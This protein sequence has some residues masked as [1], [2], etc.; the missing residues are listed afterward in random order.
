MKK[1]IPTYSN[2]NIYNVGD[3]LIGYPLEN[4]NRQNNN[5]NIKEAIQYVSNTLGVE[6]E[7][8]ER[9]VY[10]FNQYNRDKINPKKDEE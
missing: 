4:D 2:C 10:Q 3:M 8:L 1:E 7:L 6:I 9:I 5:I